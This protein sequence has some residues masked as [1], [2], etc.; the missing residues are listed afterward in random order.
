MKTEEKAKWILYSGILYL[1]EVVCLIP[2]GQ[3]REA[4]I[5]GPQS[6]ESLTHLGGVEEGDW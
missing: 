1:A 6:I 4:G 5:I 3:M 2:E